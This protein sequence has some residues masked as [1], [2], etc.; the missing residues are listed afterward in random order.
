MILKAKLD[1]FA[2]DCEPS[3]YS[4]LKKKSATL[5]NPQYL[6]ISIWSNM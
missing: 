5:L 1:I 3:V 4:K 6:S 2:N